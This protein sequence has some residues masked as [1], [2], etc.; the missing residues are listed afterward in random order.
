[1]YILFDIG[2]SKTRIAASGDLQELS[3]EPTVFES[4]ESF[5]T[6]MDQF[7]VEAKKLAGD[8]PIEG[9][10]GGIAGVLNEERKV[11]LRS[12]NKQS[13]VGQ[14]LVDRL[15]ESLGAPVIIE[16]DTA[17]VGLGE[18]HFGAGQGF[19]IVAYMTISTGVGGVKI[20]NGVIDQKSIGFEPGHQIIDI[21]G[22]L[23]PG[24]NEHSNRAPGDLE[25]YISGGSLEKRT[26]K[27]PYEVEGEE[28]WHT[29]AKWS[30][31]G[32]HNTIVHWSPN[33]V[34]LGGSMIAGQ[35]GP[36]IE[37]EEIKKHLGTAMTIFPELPVIEKATLGDF[38]G[39][40]GAM[41]LL[42]Q[43]KSTS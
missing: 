2:G 42:R 15:E 20:E 30:A 43:Q 29:L 33:A 25:A 31:V 23:C 36:V 28:I 14:S 27:K 5:D 41:A 26:G 32:L 6:D 40:H 3:G 12:P 11:L 16:N 17:V 38:G 18:A 37:V 9:L 13:W 4:T 8:Q 19:D 21:D 1:M 39:L 10:S 7:V 35:L 22:T 24:C 34:V